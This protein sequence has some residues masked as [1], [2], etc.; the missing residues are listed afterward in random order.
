MDALVTLASATLG[1]D[2]RSETR[3]LAA[4]GVTGLTDE[5]LRAQAEGFRYR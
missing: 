5:A 3:G 1:R 4:L 2:F